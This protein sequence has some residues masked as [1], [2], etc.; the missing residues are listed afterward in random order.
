MIAVIVLAHNNEA[1]LAACL[2]AVREAS[3]RRRLGGEVVLRLVVLDSC[4]DGSAAIA[5]ACGVHTLPLQVGNPDAA[6]ALGAQWASER[7]ARWVAF[8][9]ADSVVAPDWL[10]AQLARQGDAAFGHVDIQGQVD[11]DHKNL[12]RQQ[13]A[14]RAAVGIPGGAQQGGA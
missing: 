4:T 11:S 8:T 3:R 5:R 6:R 14:S 9:D 10:S 12:H 7:G 1:H 2:R 13:D